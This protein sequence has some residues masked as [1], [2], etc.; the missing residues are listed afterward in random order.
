MTL[1]GPFYA[2]VVDKKQVTSL[3]R[4]VYLPNPVLVFGSYVNNTGLNFAYEFEGEVMTVEGH[5][6]LY[7][8]PYGEKQEKKLI[9]LVD[10]ETYK[11]MTEEDAVKKKYIKAPEKKVEDEKANESKA[12]TNKGQKSKSAVSK[13]SKSK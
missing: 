2:Y 9:R 1:T 12:S 13:N 5:H 4:K 11:V 8:R 3:G 7:D 6:L 10:S